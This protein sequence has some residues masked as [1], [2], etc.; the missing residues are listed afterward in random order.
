M[1]NKK[2]IIVIII[3]LLLA[4]LAFFLCKKEKQQ[5]LPTFTLQGSTNIGAG[6]IEMKIWDSEAEDGDTVSVYFK[7]EQMVDSLPLM[8]EP[9]VVQLGKLK[10]G[11]YQLGVSAISEGNVSPASCTVTLSNGTK[12]VDFIMDAFVDSAASWNIIVQ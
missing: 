9:K 8:H 4:A 2:T 10:S 1:K 6:N 12:E 7:G 3:L 5:P 11:T